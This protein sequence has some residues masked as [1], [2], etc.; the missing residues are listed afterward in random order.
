[1]DA[2]FFVKSITILVSLGFVIFVHELG[3]FLVAR[4]AGVLVERFSIGF[5]PVLFS[6]RRGDTEY[7][8]SAIPLGGYVKMLG[9]TDTPEVLEPSPDERSY[10]NK[11][12]G[13]R[14]AIISAGVVMNVILGFVCF[15]IAFNQGVPTFAALVGTAVPGK[16]AWEAGMR[17]GDNVVG[18]NGQ[19]PADYEMLMTEVALTRPKTE[20]VRFDVERDGQHLAF[21]V[22]PV[23]EAR[24]PIIGVLNG[25]GMTLAP[26]YPTVPNSVAAQAAS[27]GFAS[28]DQVLAVNGKPVDSHLQFVKEMY[29]HR[30]EPVKV[31][32]VR[33]GTG[34]KDDV[35]VA[36]AF[37]R[38]LG[39][40][41]QTNEVVAI[42]HGSPATRG[43][44]VETGAPFV[45]Q[46]KD[47]I[48]AVDGQE[49]IDPMMLP[50][51]ITAKAGQPV[52]LTILRSGNQ[53]KTVK[54][55]VVPESIPSWIDFPEEG[56]SDQEWPVSIPSL[57]IAYKVFPT[58]RKV[59][60]G[61]PAATAETP[62]QAQDVV[63]KVFFHLD[64]PEGEVS[65]NRALDVQ[66]D[67]WPM[68]FWSMQ[69]PAVRAVTL[70]VQREQTTFDVTLTPSL[71]HN[72]PMRLRGLR[73]QP[74]M[75]ERHET[76]IF[77]AIH[78]GLVRTRTS[79]VKLY[80][81]L[82]GLFLGSISPMNLVGP[83]GIFREAYYRAER[84]PQLIEFLAL[85]SINLAVIN[86]L[87]IPVLDGGHMVFLTYEL[88]LRRQ[89]SERAVLITNYVGI[90]LILGLMVFV[91]SL[92]ILRATG[93]LKV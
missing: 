3:H 5:G 63:K 24:K 11:S 88:I 68:I 49:E 70:T 14:M 72:W 39:F 41:M 78:L 30:A 59:V 1:M 92:D 83:I 17:M 76:N 46:P 65:D 34:K 58:V 29:D 48:K 25:L 71:D 32:V 23:Q 19:S 38:T 90:F 77:S 54:V 35:A 42:Q 93:I 9:Q 57:G 50:D 36:P 8:I 44:E 82:R 69:L 10:Q 20:T 40:Q 62:L 47:V 45:I 53:P 66:E 7:A 61:G 15:V 55:K 79:I 12:V 18:I 67:R 33:K 26:K 16:P 64:L 84:L 22:R 28:E 86:F 81:I 31:S 43:T 52:V 21:D 6:F 4:W 13:K 51:V 27:P 91:L 56:I 87:P 85:L 37:F 80:L 2:G 73:F 60:P 89:P 74:A 75:T